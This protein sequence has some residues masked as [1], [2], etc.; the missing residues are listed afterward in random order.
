MGEVRYSSLKRQYLEFADSLFKKT[1]QDAKE[2]LE[3]YKKLAGL[4]CATQ[5]VAASKA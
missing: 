2:R 5:Q 3:G 4:G 1:E